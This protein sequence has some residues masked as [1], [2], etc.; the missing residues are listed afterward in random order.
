MKDEKGDVAIKKLVGL[1]P[2]IL[3]FLVDDSSEHKKGKGEQ[4]CCLKNKL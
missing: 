2:N 3:P 4:K 1:K